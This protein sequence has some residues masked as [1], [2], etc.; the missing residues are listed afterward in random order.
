MATPLNLLSRLAVQN[1]DT[2]SSIALLTNIMDGVDG[3]EVFGY[4]VEVESVRTRDNQTQQY[5]QIHTLDI[6]VLEDTANSAILDAIVSESIPAKISGY[7]PDGFFIWDEPVLIARNKQY[8]QVFASAVLATMKATPGFRGSPRKRPVHMSF[9][10]LGVYDVSDVSTSVLKAQDIFFPF[11]GV[12]LTA[13]SSSGDVGFSF[14]NAAGSEISSS[15]GT[16]PHTATI[17]A[18]TVSIRLDGAATISNP[19]IGLNGNTNF[20]I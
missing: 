1:T 19:M 4:N 5:A 3:A 2:P 12:V 10:M 11:P 18:N 20:V 6:R 13:S 17:P 15:T 16:S 14:R 8:D 9:N 7:T